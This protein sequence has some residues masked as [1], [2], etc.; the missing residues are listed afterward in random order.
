MWK[1]YMSSVR[2]EVVLYIEE[3]E[4]KGATWEKGV[5]LYRNFNSS[6]KSQTKGR[7]AGSV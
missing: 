5:F 3:C 1:T 7:A 2:S 4:R 6:L